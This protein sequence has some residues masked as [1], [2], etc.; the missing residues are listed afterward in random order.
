MMAKINIH[1]A[2]NS[3][4]SNVQKDKLLEERNSLIFLVAPLTIV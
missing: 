1:I 2:T 3:M 4:N